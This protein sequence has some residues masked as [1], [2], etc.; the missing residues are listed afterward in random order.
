MT[1]AATP[2]PMTAGP[3][4]PGPQACARVISLLDG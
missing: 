4:A 1:H 2:G 3:G